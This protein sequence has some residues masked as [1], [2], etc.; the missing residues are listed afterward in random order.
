LIYHYICLMFLGWLMFF[1]HI[2]FN[3]L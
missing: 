3:Y 2:E 1:I